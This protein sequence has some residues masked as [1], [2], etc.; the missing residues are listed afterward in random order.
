MTFMEATNPN[1]DHKYKV[2]TDNSNVSIH[3]AISLLINMIVTLSPRK[4]RMSSL[5]ST[6]NCGLLSESI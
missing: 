3:V 2:V 5:E 6:K 4:D 1:P